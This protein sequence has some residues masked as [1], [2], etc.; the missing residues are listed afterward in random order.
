MPV[1]KWNTTLEIKNE[2]PYCNLDKNREFNKT[3][4][5]PIFGR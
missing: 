5:L 1:F 4:E 3:L 2:Q